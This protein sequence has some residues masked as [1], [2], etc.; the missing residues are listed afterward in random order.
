MIWEAARATSA[1][2]HY[3]KRIKIDF[4][5]YMDGGIVANNPAWHAWYEASSM[6]TD[7]LWGC[8]TQQGCIRFLV[9]L[10]TGKGAPRNLFTDGNMFYQ[11]KIIFG[12]AMDK[13]TD[14]EGVHENMS[15][16]IN[17]FFPGAN[18]YTRFNV[19]SAL[20]GMKLDECEKNDK[21]FEK[22]FNAVKTYLRP[23]SPAR[24]QMNTLARQLVERRRSKCRAQ[25]QRYEGLS[26]PGPIDPAFSDRFLRLHDVFQNQTSASGSSLSASNGNTPVIDTS[27]E[28]I[29][30]PAATLNGDTIPAAVP[31]IA[32]FFHHDN[33]AQRHPS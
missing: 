16:M 5:E 13:L 22:I 4:M 19:P 11:I 15:D 29:V 9:S 8:G 30:A 23:K 14:P 32:G 21:T 20:Q 3:F 1:A 18:I 26:T 7:N 31:R 28:D 27:A 10:G 24:D 6:H 25:H 12:L 17:Q 2:P 33:S